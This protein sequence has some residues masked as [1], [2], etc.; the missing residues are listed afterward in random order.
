[1]TTTHS[2]R[3]IR[4]PR[5]AVYH[6][7]IDAE[8]VRHWM[9]P[10]DMT[11]EIHT[12]E[13]RQGGAFRIS[14]TYDAPDGTGKT[15]GR[16]DTF[17][18]TFVELVPD[19]KVV[20]SVEFETDVPDLRGLMTITYELHDADDG[21]ELVGRHDD[22]PPGVSPADNELGTRMSMDKLARLVEGPSTNRQP[23]L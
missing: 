9:V 3:F 22:L 7:L 12:F 4:A 23:C 19:T 21:T 18:G 17:H 10:D 15:T 20:Q 13:G 8:S 6:A 11:S 2:R 14:L 1:M 5:A 16:T